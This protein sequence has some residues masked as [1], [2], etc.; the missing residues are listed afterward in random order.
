LF[1]FL[2]FNRRSFKSSRSVIA[3]ALLPL[4]FALLLMSSFSH[5]QQNPNIQRSADWLHLEVKKGD[6]L[7][8]L[9]SRAGLSAQEVLKISNATS[10]ARTFVRMI[11]GETLSLKV[12]AKKIS[13]IEYW[14]TADTYIHILKSLDSD[15]FEIAQRTINV[16]KKPEVTSSPAIDTKN[17]KQNNL[18]LIDINDFSTIE[19][20]IIE[21]TQSEKLDSVFTKAGLNAQDVAN[22]INAST[23]KEYFKEM[24]NGDNFNFLIVDNELLQLEYSNSDNKVAFTRDKNLLDVYTQTASSAASDN[25]AQL[26]EENPIQA[27]L[28]TP[29]SE[30][31]NWIYYNV[32]A[33]DNLSTLFIRA[34]LSHTDVHYVDKATNQEKIFSRMQV[35]EKLAFLI[36]SGELIKVKY[37]INPLK[38]VLVSRTDK[39]AYIYETLERSPIKK[40]VLVGGKIQNSLYLDALNAGLTSNLTMNFAKVF[41]WDVDFSQDLQPGDEF[42][43]VYE[44][45]TIDGSKIKD[46]NILAAQFKTGGQ[47]L[48]GIFYRDSQGDVGFYTPDGRSM[49][50]A[51]LRM[52]VE[53]ARI[54]S[55]FNPRRRHPVLN[56]IRA[57]K[58]VDYAA[59][60][61]TPIM[62]SGNGKIIF[63]GRKNGY[64]NTIIIQHG[65]DIN[66]LYAHM[67]GF[68]K[69]FKTGSRVQQGQVIGYVGATGMVTGAHLHYEFR[70]SGVHKN[71]LTVKLDQAERLPDSEL[72]NFKQV[73]AKV[74]TKFKSEE[75]IA[76]KKPNANL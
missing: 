48:I 4:S 20:T 13:E 9:F 56:K 2:N 60:T 11:P 62:A 58:G 25:T 27:L 55:K 53:F 71:P 12:N 40:Q 23:D 3:V 46:G 68:N 72:E 8:T 14:I 39:T 64:G 28:N 67:S 45:L 18:T 49:R 47:N 43:V 66:T 65:S 33:G 73:A 30:T 41:S 6:N 7:S 61:G 29:S 1:S 57:H 74:M 54:S 16:I 70:V 37:I 26:V 21:V 59:K 38:S 76:S 36:R 75:T 51:F 32:Q 24:Q 44:Q 19:R 52:P 15:Q 5:S 31:D 50:K 34:G 22:I 42:Q 17:L 69:D 35:G 63:R 10:E